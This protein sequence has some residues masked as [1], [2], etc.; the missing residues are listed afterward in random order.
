MQFTSQQSDFLLDVSRSAIRRSLG[1]RLAPT[2]ESDDDGLRRPAGCFVTLHTMDGHR[3]RGCIGQLSADGP[4][5]DLVR[6]MSR[7]ALRDPRFQ[8]FPVTLTE[9][10]KLE[11]EITVLSPMEAAESPLDFEL[12]RHG[13]YMTIGRAGGCFLPQVARETGWS[14][15]QLLDR[16]CSEKMGLEPSQWRRPGARL[17]R[18]ETVIL[19]PQPFRT[20]C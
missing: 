8:D 18:F 16:L 2:P 17:S 4:L 11:L 15:E 3:L 7:A 6:E 14:K 20:G 10:P 1:D 5:L 13:I 9:L 19:G 12:L